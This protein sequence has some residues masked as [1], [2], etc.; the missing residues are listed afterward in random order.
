MKTKEIEQ[1]E[2][3]DRFFD[4]LNLIL[5]YLNKFKEANSK[6][7]DRVNGHQFA[8]IAIHEL[9]SASKKITNGTY[10]FTPYLELLKSKGR[11]KQPRIVSIPTI[12]DRLILKKTNTFLQE[13]FPE[14]IP[15]SIASA[16]VRD[17]KSHLESLDK[18]DKWVLSTDI[19]TFYDSINRGKLKNILKKK[20]ICTEILSLIDDATSNITVPKNTTRKNYNRYKSTT[21]IPQGLSISNILASIYMQDIDKKISSLNVKYYRYVDDVLIIGNKSDVEDAYKKLKSKLAY[22]GL[23]IH[24]IKSEKCSL[25]PIDNEFIYLGYVFNENSITVRNSS[26]ENFLQSISSKISNYKHNSVKKLK[27]YSYLNTQILKEIFI[28]EINDKIT[29]AYYQGKRYGWIG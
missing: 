5:E 10:K 15:K 3:F 25:K 11:G 16:Y 7:I 19:K 8:K 17:L 14:S 18:A 27:K 13:I 1:K 24:S 23:S 21:G 28:D 26:K 20:I 6:G 22:K 4:P 2:I 12:R 9:N 29:G